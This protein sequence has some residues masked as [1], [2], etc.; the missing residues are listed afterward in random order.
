MSDEQAERNARLK[1]T[2]RQKE[3]PLNRTGGAGQVVCPSNQGQGVK[4]P[5]GHLDPYRK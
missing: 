2:M 3:T 4:T 5:K 1:A